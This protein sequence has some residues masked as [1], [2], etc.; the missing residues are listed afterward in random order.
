MHITKIYI[1]L[2][3][4]STEEFPYKYSLHLIEHHTLEH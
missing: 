2:N 4:K 1:F 3:Q